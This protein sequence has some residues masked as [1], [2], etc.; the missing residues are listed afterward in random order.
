MT[1]EDPKLTCP[2]IPLHCVVSE[3]SVRYDRTAAATRRGSVK[4]VAGVRSRE[5]SNGYLTAW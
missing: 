5:A 3:A 1:N 4:L 2:E